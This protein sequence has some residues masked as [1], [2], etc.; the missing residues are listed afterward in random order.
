[1]ES[2]LFG[3]SLLCTEAFGGNQYSH[4]PNTTWGRVLWTGKS[5][6]QFLAGTTY[7]SL[8]QTKMS[9]SALESMQPPILFGGYQGSFPWGLNIKTVKLTT[10][11]HLVLRLRMTG[12]IHFP[13]LCACMAWPGPT[14]P[15]PPPN[16]GFMFVW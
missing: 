2:Y 11:L 1:M 4:T 3:K 9:R 6:V 13:I 12:A 10:S 8:L 16:K 5:K 15:L 14:L 7:F